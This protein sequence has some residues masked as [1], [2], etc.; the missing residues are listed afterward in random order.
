MLNK[1]TNKFCGFLLVISIVTFSCKKE[2]RDLKEVQEQETKDFLGANISNFTKD[3]SG[4]YYQILEQPTGDFITNTTPIFYF[5]NVKTTNGT[6]LLNTDKYNYLRAYLTDIK[7]IGFNKSIFALIKKGGKIRSIIPSYL[8]FGKDGSGSLIKGNALIDAT[9][10]VINAKT[11][12]AAEDSIITKY[13][14]NLD[15]TFVRDV[16]GVYYSIIE[17]GTG[18]ANVT[19]QSSITVNYIGK[20]FN[21]EQFDASAVGKPLQ[22]NFTAIIKGWQVLTKIK[23]GGKMRMLIPSQK[24]YGANGSRTI[25][26][27]CPLDFEIELV[28]VK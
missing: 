25:P 10:E 5:Q 9:F 1:M 6:P 24:A 16:S 12:E 7:P 11:G 14:K 18:T 19:L 8:A 4:F 15:L 3:T 17:P 21:G 23:K 2:T 27:N 26:A 28:D 13:K 20:F 22:T